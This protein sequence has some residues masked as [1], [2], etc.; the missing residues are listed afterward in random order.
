MLLISS[1][2][3][4]RNDAYT[5]EIMD[6]CTRFKQKILSLTQQMVEDQRHSVK[7]EVSVWLKSCP[8]V[9]GGCWR[10]LQIMLCA[11]CVCR[12]PLCL[13]SEAFCGRFY[14]C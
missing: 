4:V 12:A 10:I 9:C 2:L 5:G 14:M 7:S 11:D 8:I 1:V 13:Q 6:R 3:F